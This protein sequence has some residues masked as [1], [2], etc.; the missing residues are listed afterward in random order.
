MVPDPARRSNTGS[1]TANRRNSDRV[2]VTYSAT[3]C[4][5]D[6]EVLAK[7]QAS[8]ISEGGVFVV[9]TSRDG[10]A[11]TDR[12]ILQLE[13]S[14]SHSRTRSRTTHMKYL[15]RLVRMRSIGHLYGLGLQFL[16]R[17]D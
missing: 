1:L 12:L 16:D 15:V 11:I 17:L 6:G 9:A 13:P 2:P 5:T 8:N 10:L 4:D 14:N 3:V 7:G